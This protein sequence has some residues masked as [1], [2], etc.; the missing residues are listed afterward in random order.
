MGG[1]GLL[2]LGGGEKTLTVEEPSLSMAQFAQARVQTPTMARPLTQP[3]NSRQF[4]QRA[5]A[6]PSE[7]DP[8]PL[9]KFDMGRREAM[10]AGIAAA[11]S[12]PAFAEE[13]AA[14]AAPA[15][16]AIDPFKVKGDPAKSMK[17][18]ATVMRQSALKFNSQR[19]WE[20]IAGAKVLEQTPTLV[21][22][23]LVTQELVATKSINC[24]EQPKIGSQKVWHKFKDIVEFKYN[25]GTNAIDVAITPGKTSMPGSAAKIVESLRKE[26]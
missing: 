22:G 25:S 4:M 1:L 26:Y 20:P 15:A 7:D 11:F 6:T 14:P 24:G 12:A 13:A 19:I 18:I 5:A 16:P 10:A 21:K 2:L 23:E 17:R 8:V 3:V 9:E